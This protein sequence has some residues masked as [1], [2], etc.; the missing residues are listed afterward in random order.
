MDQGT[1]VG[2]EIADGR[3]LVERFV[4]DGHPVDVAFWVLTDEYP[5]WSLYLVTELHDRQGA[6]AAYQAKNESASKLDPPIEPSLHV[7]IIG[8]TDPVAVDAIAIASKLT[9]K[10]LAT[11][12]A[13]RLGR[14]QVDRVVFYPSWVYRT[15][16]M[17]AMTTEEVSREV[18]RLMGRGEVSPEPS[19]VELGD[20]TRFEGVPFSIELD[21]ESNVVARFVEAGRS[22]PRVVRLDEVSA[23][24]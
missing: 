1:L 24:A 19:R 21:A 23:I 18:L 14:L 9:G 4:A 10:R 5:F 22:A 16:R 7:K 11:S 8:P 12:Q 15:T 20:G 6:I 13:Y 2:N 3:R 17:G